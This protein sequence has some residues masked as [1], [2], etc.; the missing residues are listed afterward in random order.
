MIEYLHFC[1]LQAS[2]IVQECYYNTEPTKSCQASGWKL[3]VGWFQEAKA[4]L[5]QPQ[6]QAEFISKSAHRQGHKL[7][8][9]L[10]QL[11]LRL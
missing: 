11:E 6:A 3:H 5:V 1:A 9:D 8:W 7:G 4:F 10:L 2:P